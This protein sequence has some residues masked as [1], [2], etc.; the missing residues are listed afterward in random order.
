MTCDDVRGAASRPVI[1][2]LA[3]LLMA[4]G[5]AM[6]AQASPSKVETIDGSEVKRV[7]LDAKAAERLAIQTE[8]VRKEKVVFRTVVLGQVEDEASAK[9][10]ATSEPASASTPVTAPG[11]KIRVLVLLDA[12]DDEDDV[13]D[14]LDEDDDDTAEIIAADDDDED[15]EPLMAKRV[16]MASGVVETDSGMLYFKIPPKAHHNLTPGQRV[17][18]RLAAPGSGAEKIIVPYSAVLYDAKG[19]AWV[20]TNPEPLVFVRHRVTID[21]IDRG[22]AVLQDGPA[23]GTKVVTV[24]AAELFGAES[25]VGH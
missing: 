6:L 15:D 13:D 19:D 8:P 20:Y 9:S 21:K 18:V 16:A 11:G 7:T 12:A 2:G 4:A 25:G 3:A 14:N 1:A 24:G 5:S 10:T 17:G 23:V 22:R